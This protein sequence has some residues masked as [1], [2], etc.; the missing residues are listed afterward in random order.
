LIKK[1]GWNMDMRASVDLETEESEIWLER[2][3]SNTSNASDKNKL[4]GSPVTKIGDSSLEDRETVAQRNNGNPADDDKSI[5]F[6]TKFEGDLSEKK[7]SNEERPDAMG[8][9]GDEDDPNKEDPDDKWIKDT[10]KFYEESEGGPIEKGLD[11][12]EG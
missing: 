3:N 6:R 4:G 12:E 9:N 7:P 5:E 2:S 11:S 10:I 1:K 8:L